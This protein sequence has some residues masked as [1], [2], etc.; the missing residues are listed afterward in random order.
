V[1]STIVDVVVAMAVVVIGAIIRAMV[2]V[3]VGVTSC[4]AKRSNLAVFVCNLFGT[5][6]TTRRLY[7]MACMSITR[8]TI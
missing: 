4:V 5:T 1:A 3:Y 6:N 2:V 8:E 7:C